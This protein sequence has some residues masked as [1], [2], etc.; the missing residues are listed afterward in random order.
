MELGGEQEQ[1][2]GASP[3][4]QQQQHQPQSNTLQQRLLQLQENDRRLQQALAEREAIRHALDTERVLIERKLSQLP[5][6][7]QLQPADLANHSV[8]SRLSSCSRAKGM[9]F[10]QVE[11]LDALAVLSRC[12]QSLH[13]EL[14]LVKQSLAA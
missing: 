2:P 13:D 12:K 3:Q 5:V 6:L 7:P 14:A 4:L 9:L 8:R 1:P 11:V 10:W